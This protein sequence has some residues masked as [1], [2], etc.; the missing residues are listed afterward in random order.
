MFEGVIT[1]KKMHLV[2]QLRPKLLQP[3][4]SCLKLTRKGIESMKRMRTE[5][6]IESLLVPDDSR[7]MLEQDLHALSQQRMSNEDQVEAL[8]QQA[9]P[10]PRKG[11]PSR[12]VKAVGEINANTKVPIEERRPWIIVSYERGGWVLYT[13]EG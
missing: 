5:T 2:I 10:R 11:S 3:A 6:A 9:F 7:S 1:V 4:Q 13:V 8:K 12:H